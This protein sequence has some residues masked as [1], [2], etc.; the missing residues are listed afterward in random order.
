LWAPSRTGGWRSDSDFH[1]IPSKGRDTVDNLLDRMAALESSLQEMQRERCAL[2]IREGSARRRLRLWQ[3]IAAALALAGALAL[4]LR[5]ATAQQTGGLPA[6]EKRVTTVEAGLNNEIQNRQNGDAAANAYT[7][8]QVAIVQA[9]LNSET[10]DR[11]AN[12]ADLQTQITHVQLQPGPQGP[13]GQPGPPGPG[14]TPDQV[15]TLTSLTNL[16]LANNQ[17]GRPYFSRQGNDVTIEGANLHIVNGLGATNGYPAD[18]GFIDPPATESTLT[19][20]N[21]LGNLIVGYNELGSPTGTDD[22]SGSHNLVLGAF[23]NYSSFGALLAGAGNSVS[24]PFGSVSGGSSNT[25]S[26]AYASVSGGFNVKEPAGIGWAAGGLF[27]L[28]PSG[29]PGAYHSP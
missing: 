15:N 2:E 20:V 25:V 7:D 23:Q 28:S 22:R 10:A 12:V 19:H 4:P 16:F 17:F 6:L 3:G 13:R 5:T 11:K 8:G 21:G 18:P 27:F 9:G 24:G 14:F 29:G 1:F 26:G